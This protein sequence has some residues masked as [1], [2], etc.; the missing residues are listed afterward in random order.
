[1]SVKDILIRLY[2]NLNRIF[3]SGILPP[4]YIQFNFA[5]KN[6]KEWKLYFMKNGQ[7][8][9]SINWKLLN[10]NET[11]LY[12]NMLHQMAHIYN[13]I[14]EIADTSKSCRYHNK[15]WDNAVRKNGIITAHNA[16]VGYYAV[17]I[18]DNTVKKIQP[19][20][21]FKKFREIVASSNDEGEKRF[22]AHKCPKCN[23]IILAVPIIGN[24]VICGYDHCE[25]IRID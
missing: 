22:V 12:I 23:R 21:D 7:Y 19:F 5:E 6:K 15:K 4:V 10:C 16:N 3:Y 13:W 18:S 11:D 1:M 25:F 24:N 9:I 17:G 20:F 2:D 8:C 14:N